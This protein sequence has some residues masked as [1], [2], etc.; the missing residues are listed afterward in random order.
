MN[1]QECLQKMDAK[2][3]AEIYSRRFQ[4]HRKLRRLFETE[5]VEDFVN[6][7]LGIS[8]STGNYSATEHPIQM[9]RLILSET[10]PSDVFELAQKLDQVDK[11]HLPITI[12]KEGIRNLKIS[13]GSEMAMMLRPNELWVGN[14]RTYW[15][16]L[17]VEHGNHKKANDQL[18]LYYDREGE[19]PYEIWTYLYLR[20]E[21]QL[22]DLGRAAGEV[23]TES[24]IEPGARIFLWADAVATNLFGTL[25]F[26]P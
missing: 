11:K 8:D 18:E 10:Q 19:M 25:A 24:G 2:E 12:E 3:V 26:K 4:I 13:I 22:R 21:E 1:L 16:S 14:K 6:L 23:A 5:S 15:A 20:A 9:G 17:L 7:A